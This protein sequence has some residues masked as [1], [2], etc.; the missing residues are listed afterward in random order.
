MDFGVKAWKR[1]FIRTHIVLVYDTHDRNY[2]T[3]VRKLV[4]YLEHNR[5][6]AYWHE[7]MS[8]IFNLLW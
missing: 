6:H 8:E 5:H 3:R 4:F 1:K 2:C 7:D